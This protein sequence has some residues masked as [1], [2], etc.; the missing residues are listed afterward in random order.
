MTTIYNALWHPVLPFA[1]M[2]TGGRNAMDRRER[3]GTAALATDMKSAPRLWIHAASVGEV[4]AVRPLA[5]GLMR[6]YPNTAMVVT[7]M[8]LA[9]R[10]AAERR[11]E[12]ALAY[13][14]APLDRAA[15]VRSFLGTV[16]PQIVLIAETELWP[17]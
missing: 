4:E 17:N 3:L 2:A 5:H 15:N 16:R 7:T 12:G 11:I 8:T 1:L 14:L 10:A 13:R 9:G 6:E